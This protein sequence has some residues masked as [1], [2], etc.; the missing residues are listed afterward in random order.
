MTTL[1]SAASARES[2]LLYWLSDRVREL[3][4]A[5]ELRAERDLLVDIATHATEPLRTMVAG[6]VSTG[7]STLINALVGQE[8]ARVQRVETT[9]QVTWYRHPSLPVPPALGREH[10][11]EAVAFGLSSTVVLIDTPGVNT[12]SGNQVATEQLL[13]AS[14]A[15]DGAAGS[16]SVMLYLCGSDMSRNALRNIRSFA[17]MAQGPLGDV[18]NVVLIGARADE[19]VG[20]DRDQL[21]RLESELASKAGR[22]GG[23]SV[24]VAQLL[25][26]TARTGGVDTWLLGHLAT[27][28]RW[29]ELRSAAEHGWNVLELTAHEVADGSGTGNVDELQ[30]L[31]DDIPELHRRCGTAQVLLHGTAAMERDPTGA[32]DAVV[33]EFERLSGLTAL[34]RTLAAL[35]A[36]GDVLTSAAVVSR[37]RRL[38]SALGASVGRSLA[39]VLDDYRRQPGVVDLTRRGT[40]L[41]LESGAF[42]FL[43]VELTSSAANHLRGNGPPPDRATVRTWAALAANRARPTLARR[44]AETVVDAATSSPD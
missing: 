13:A 3:A 25:A 19:T 40:A 16:A 2:P 18:G 1:G 27:I 17:S 21:G 15:T 33:A 4:E 6:D 31:A 34:E 9:T 41:V 24:A 30:A 35:A 36:D 38:R 26:A 10:H 42:P 28:A 32:A 11:A 20:L 23:R 5:P 39:G 37:L 29:P 22:H 8:V 43:S 7:K 12:V 44:V 14:R